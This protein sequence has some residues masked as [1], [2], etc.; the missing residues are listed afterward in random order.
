MNNNFALIKSLNQ[1]KKIII[2]CGHYGSGKTNIAVNLAIA[3]KQIDENNKVAICD[4]DI[5]N[6]YF[7]TADAVKMLEDSGVH[8]VIPEYANSNVDIPSVPTELSS[9]LMKDSRFDYSIIDVGG[10]EGAVVLGRYNAAICEIGYDMIYV[11]NQYRPLTDNP[12]DAVDLMH[13]IEAVS[14]LKCSHIANN[15]NLG[16][17]T[18]AADVT[19]SFSYADKIC[20]ITSLPLIFTSHIG[21]SDINRS[22][23]RFFDM[24]NATK[25]L[26]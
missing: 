16:I 17:E 8:C 9:L 18:T 22:E 20:E 12:E 7:R 21:I 6:P 15:S 1:L 11:V 14:R 19:D 24:K 10:D 2:V 3:L 13:D 4:L 25:Q 23:Y 5:V 26:F